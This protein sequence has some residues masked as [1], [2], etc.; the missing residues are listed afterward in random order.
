MQLPADRRSTPIPHW[1]NRRLP[2]GKSRITGVID[3]ARPVGFKEYP[4]AWLTLS[5]QV[6]EEYHYKGQR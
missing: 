2:G 5:L 3:H 4:I 6:V 1:E